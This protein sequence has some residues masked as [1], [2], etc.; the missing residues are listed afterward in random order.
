MPLQA[1]KHCRSGAT[2]L[3]ALSDDPSHAPGR[4]RRRMTAIAGGG[5]H[6][7]ALSLIDPRSAPCVGAAENAQA[8][9]IGARACAVVAAVTV[10]VPCGLRVTRAAPRAL[11]SLQTSRAADRAAGRAE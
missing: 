4:Q 1:G 11:D 7:R 5:R 6:R 8:C 3:A 9:R 10:N 2:P